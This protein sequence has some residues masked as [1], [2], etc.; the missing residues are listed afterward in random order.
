MALNENIKK[1]SKQIQQRWF[2]HGTS[3]IS[4]IYT[5]NQILQVIMAS[6]FYALTKLEG[7]WSAYLQ[8]HQPSVIIEAYDFPKNDITRCITMEV[9]II[10][11]FDWMCIFWSATCREE[12][13]LSWVIS[14]G[15]STW[16][17]LDSGIPYKLMVNN[18]QWYFH[19]FVYV[20]GLKVEWNKTYGQ[21]I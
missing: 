20:K 5:G 8:S 3:W 16:L 1:H 7:G 17:N 21:I 19:T 9:E 10:H 6:R 12:Q 15:D 18:F 11:L 14:F 13:F 4:E 2:K